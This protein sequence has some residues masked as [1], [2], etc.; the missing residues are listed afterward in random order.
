MLA[1][2]V[3]N[4]SGHTRPRLLVP[5]QLR[6]L[7]LKQMHPIQYPT[8]VREE[9]RSPEWK[10]IVLILRISL[11]S[12]DAQSQKGRY[13]CT[14]IFESS[15]CFYTLAQSVLQAFSVHCSTPTLFD[16]NNRKGIGEEEMEDHTKERQQGSKCM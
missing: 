12:R 1:S 11:I 8:D 6:V 5:D 3:S 16:D 10:E 13:I 14:E 7:L 2:H 15:K 9:K 4:N